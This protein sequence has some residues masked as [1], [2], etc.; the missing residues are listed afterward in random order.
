MAKK[1]IW[2]GIIPGIFGYGI[3]VV[4]ESEAKCLTALRREYKEWKKS[5]VDSSTNF[6]TSFE[7]WGGSVEEIELGKGYFDDFKS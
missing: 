2:V 1:T 3:S 4:D 5:Y 7:N 6:K